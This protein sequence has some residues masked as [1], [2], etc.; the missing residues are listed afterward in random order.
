[1]SVNLAYLLRSV[2]NDV[3][4]S[5]LHQAAVES[6]RLEVLPWRNRLEAHSLTW[7]QAFS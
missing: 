4:L 1:M 6:D 3:E 2:V 5:K 7:V